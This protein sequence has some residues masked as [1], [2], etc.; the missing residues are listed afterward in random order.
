MAV[1]T[2]EWQRYNGV[3]AADFG[4]SDVDVFSVGIIWRF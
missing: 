2:A 4:E 1:S 3:K